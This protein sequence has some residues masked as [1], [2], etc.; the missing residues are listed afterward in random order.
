MCLFSRGS[1]L[2]SKCGKNNEVAGKEQPSLLLMLLPHFDVSFGMF[3]YLSL[4]GKIYLFLTMFQHV[5]VF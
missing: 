4:L 3:I 5:F 1:G 2:T